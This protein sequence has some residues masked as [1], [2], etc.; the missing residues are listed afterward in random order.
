MSV[1][2][3]LFAALGGIAMLLSSCSPKAGEAVVLEVGSARVTLGEYEQFYRKNSTPA[4]DSA[5]IPMEERERFLDLLTRYKLKLMDAG[6]KNL[7]D[8]PDVQSE[9]SEYRTSLATTFIIEKQISEPGIRRLY[10]RKTEEIRG[11]H[12]LVRVTPEM[13]P[14][15]T[16]LAYNKAMRLIGLLGAGADFDSLALAESEDPTVKNNSGDLYYF[17]GGQMVLPFEDAAYAMKAGEISSKPVRTSFGYHILKITD[18]KPVRGA[19]KVRHIMALTKKTPNDTADTA[20]ALAKVRAWQDSLSNGADFVSLAKAVSEDVGS[21]HNG[22]ELGWFERKR[23]VQPFDEACFLLKPGEVSP[24]VATPYGYHLIRLDSVMPMASYEEL[25][26]VPGDPLKKQY[27]Q[28]RFSDDYNRFIDSLMRKF[29]YRFNEANFSAMLAV[30]DSNETTEDSAWD[31]GI[32]DSLRAL[33]LISISGRVYTVDSVLV[34]LLDRPELHNT[35]LRRVD[36]ERQFRKISE[37]LL[38]VAEGSG[39]EKRSPEFGALMKDYTDGIVLYRA[40]QLEVWNKTAVTDSGL[41]A[42]WEE[43]R[44]EFTFPA[45]VTF[46]EMNF[47][48]DTLALIIYDSLTR[49]A[50]FAALAAL[51]NWD[52]SLRANGGVTGPVPADQDDVT[53]LVSGMS[54][55]QISEPLPIEGGYLIVKLVALDPPQE[56]TFEQAGA[57]LSNAYQDFESKRLE[58]I[59]LD[60]VRM[61]HPVK[62]YPEV[63]KRAFSTPGPSDTGVPIQ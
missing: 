3:G 48:S 56:K 22:G 5:G 15:D 39:L 27:Q 32:T 9:L 26:A 57:E 44:A 14:G 8:D 1:K 60:R 62:Q 45:K 40:E 51:H 7:I 12:I 21:A 31:G 11:K 2:T 18:R 28:I 61:K 50:D 33:P 36:L 63:L 35:L 59:W 42:Y 43:H 16:L 34:M 6:D 29:S 53:A 47:E 13:K 49:G 19:I 54:V 58:G 24:I 30:L 46:A 55:G 17:T 41:R 23:Y 37:G 25:R 20:A 4:D 38:L 52:D 10:D